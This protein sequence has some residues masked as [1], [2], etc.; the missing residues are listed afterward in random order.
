MNPSPTTGSEQT[1]VLG[2]T[3]AASAD[4]TTHEFL[5]AGTQLHEFEI[6]ALV[7]EGGFGVVYLAYDHQLQR[8]IALKEYL[9]A[10]LAVRGRGHE[11]TLR[12]QR[13]AETFAKGLQSFVNEAR[14]LARFDHPALVKVHRFWEAN[15]TAYMVMPYYDG[16]TLKS[17]RQAMPQAPD[18]SWI[19]LLLTPLLDAL[20][21]IHGQDCLHRDIAPDNILLVEGKPVLLDFGA[22][23][24]V[25]GDMTQ[26]LTVILKPGYAPVEQYAEMPGIRQGP[27]TDLYALGAVVHFLITGQAPPSSVGRL[28]RDACPALEISAAGRYS[29]S[30]LRSVDRCL[31]VRAEDRPQSVAQLR[32]LL[33]QA[34]T[35]ATT[36]ID[37]APAGRDSASPAHVQQKRR[38]AWSI[39][40]TTMVLLGGWML[41]ASPS[42]TPE[43]GTTSTL[44]ATGASPLT[45][46]AAAGT[47]PA[48]D[49]ESAWLAVAQ[50]SS[51]DHALVVSG[52]RNP[53]RTG[54]DSLEFKLSSARDGWLYLLLWDKANGD[55]GLLLPN[56]ADP[57]N[58]IEAG[59]AL[60]LP[61]PGWRYV[62]DAPAGQWEVLLLVTESKRDFPALGQP[63]DGVMRA[64]SRQRVEQALASS[65]LTALSGVPQC[66]P[67]T[68]CPAGYG[69][70]RLTLQE[71]DA[72]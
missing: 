39:L 15:G 62:A 51:P 1:L 45:T 43:P 9:P 53:L 18:E 27:W 7:G 46:P 68:R 47:A 66:S 10:T 30:L 11:V 3:A 19:R 20:D 49:L 71:V 8:R 61:R 63:S 69:A 58:R 5:P 4:T 14:L 40:A 59:T 65:G 32:E 2:S 44:P 25:I 29:P 33:E 36:S 6:T 56:E 42:R 37:A 67:G 64:A 57:D 55:I 50:A 26:A 31:A 54:Q 17:A 72:P 23:R 16:P 41:Q 12:S 48:H 70:L 52:V 34:A 38:K 35:P 22:A 21:L 60:Q 24:Q 28:M 13:H